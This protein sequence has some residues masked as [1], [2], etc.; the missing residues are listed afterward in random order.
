MSQ[1]CT[2]SRLCASA[3]LRGGVMVAPSRLRLRVTTGKGT[4]M[5]LL[6]R[7]QRHPPVL[8]V[9]MHSARHPPQWYT[10]YSHV[11]GKAAVA[12][13]AVV[14]AAAAVVAGVCHHL[15]HHHAPEKAHARSHCHGA[16]TVRVLRIPRVHVHR[17][18]RCALLRMASG[19]SLRDRDA[20]DWHAAARGCLHN[21]LRVHVRVHGGWHRHTLLRRERDAPS[22]A[23]TRQYGARAHEQRHH[24]DERG[25]SIP[26]EVLGVAALMGADGTRRAT[27]VAAIRRRA[28]PA[29]G[30]RGAAVVV[31]ARSAAALPGGAVRRLRAVTPRTA[32]LLALGEALH[33]GLRCLRRRNGLLVVRLCVGLREEHGENQGGG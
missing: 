32:A 9:V 3:S 30:R 14:A 17:L 11:G 31:A 12:T 22:V 2:L 19:H 23:R 6:A 13:A 8:G 28:R 5:G 15:A 20:R 18:A 16:T 24:H 4:R 29:H 1:A 26:L 27:I 21:V 33:G 25:H 7:R 10:L